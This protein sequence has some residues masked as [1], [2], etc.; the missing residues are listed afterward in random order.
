[1]EFDDKRRL[2]TAAVFTRSKRKIAMIPRFPSLFVNTAENVGDCIRTTYYIYSR[3]QRTPAKKCPL[4]SRVR[5]SSRRSSRCEKEGTGWRNGPKE[6]RQNG[7]ID[8]SEPSRAYRGPAETGP[9][10]LWGVSR[11]RT[12]RDPTVASGPLSAAKKR[13]PSRWIS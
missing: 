2:Q 13:R 5:V 8:D 10:S 11:P 4:K 9:R 12:D 7:T 1:M 3:L 6:G